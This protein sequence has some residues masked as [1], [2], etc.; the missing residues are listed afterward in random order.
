MTDYSGLTVLFVG[1]LNAY[2]KGYSRLKAFRALGAK[3][4]AFSHTP[5]GNPETG[6]AAPSVPFRIAWKLGFHLDTEGANGWLPR[7]AA[8]LRPD[9]VWI[10]KGNMVRP[11]TLR[12]LR[13]LCPA[14]VIA[15]YTD[16]DMVNRTNRT[17]FYALGLR[18]YD[19]VF[20]TKSYNADPLELPAMGA[21]RVV[22]V[23]KAYDPDRHRPMALGAA[24][25]EWLACDVGFIG[26]FER[27]RA[28]DMLHVAR[29]GI[30]VRI[31]GNGWERF[32]PGEKNLTIERRA[33]VNSTDDP[34][35]TKGIRATRINLTFL[36]KA[37]RDLQ[38]DRSIEIP[39]CG[40]FML[41]EYSDEHARLFEEGREAAFFRSRDDL[42]D[43]LRYYL[44]HEDE[45]AAIA[46]AGRRRCIEGGYS[47]KDRVAFMLNT[48]FD[49]KAM[50]AGR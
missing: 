18:H 2:S 39:A 26:S 45:R 28:D 49:G 37:N 3:V 23:D 8:K 27:P 43:R 25:T 44:A 6:F 19:V 13:S 32:R 21:R 5:P 34:L 46:A 17:W 47:H 14:A 29:S 40:G 36:R 31:W 9:L 4:D 33:L 16:D 24:E 48:L 7:A 12:R 22:M 10:E 41:A 30:P 35:Y 42:V 50:E 38:T 11:A 20:T 15:S 1:D